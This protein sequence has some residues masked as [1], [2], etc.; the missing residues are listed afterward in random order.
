MKPF[1]K[2]N[3]VIAM[4]VLAVGVIFFEVG[5]A[6]DDHVP[7]HDEIKASSENRLKQFDKMVNL[8]EVQKKTIEAR[9]GGPAYQNPA[10]AEAMAKARAHGAKIGPDGRPN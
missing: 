6:N 1:S 8:P 9:M 7:T 2:T 4:G 10:I 3:I 5:C